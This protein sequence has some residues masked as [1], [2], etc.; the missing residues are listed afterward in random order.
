[1]APIYRRTLAS[2]GLN[3]RMQLIGYIAKLTKD[4]AQGSGRNRGSAKVRPPEQVEECAR[5]WV[6]SKFRAKEKIR[7]RESLWPSVNWSF[8]LVHAVAR[9]PQELIVFQQEGVTCHPFSQ[10]LTELSHRP[11]HTYS[12]SAGGDLAEIVAYYDSEKRNQLTELT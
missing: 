1:M 2:G 6:H 8:H 12:G 11:E 5:D 9:E 4:M 3:L 10:L 7:V